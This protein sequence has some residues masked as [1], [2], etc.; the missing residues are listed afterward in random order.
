MCFKF[1]IGKQSMRTN[2]YFESSLS[3]PL[4]FPQKF[5]DYLKKLKKFI[6]QFI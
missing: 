5:R 4:I 6:S 1:N 2:I 3:Y